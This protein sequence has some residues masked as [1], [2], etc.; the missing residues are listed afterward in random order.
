M[1]QHG[2]ARRRRQ[3]RRA[4]EATVHGKATEAPAGERMRPQKLSGPKP[5]PDAPVA[6]P[7]AEITRI[8][9]SARHP[10]GAPESV[11]EAHAAGR[12]EID[13]ARSIAL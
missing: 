6:E 7:V 5:P 4:Q 12:A 13:R 11:N 9:P 3:G 1:A 2:W 10:N 8:S